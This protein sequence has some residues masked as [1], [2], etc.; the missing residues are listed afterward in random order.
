VRLEHHG[1]PASHRQKHD[2][3]WSYFLARLRTVAGSVDR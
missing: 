3:G 2:D 1:L